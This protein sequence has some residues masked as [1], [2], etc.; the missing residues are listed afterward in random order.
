[1]KLEFFHLNTFREI[2]Q[3]N[4]PQLLQ[5]CFYLIFRYFGHLQPKIKSTPPYAPHTLPSQCCGAFREGHG[6]S[7]IDLGLM[8]SFSLSSH[9]AYC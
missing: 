4:Y 9:S 5:I 3:D 6:L 2:V 8:L 1:M 7:R